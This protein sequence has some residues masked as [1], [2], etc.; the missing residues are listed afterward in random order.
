MLKYVQVSHNDL[1]NR[2]TSKLAT[3]IYDNFIHL[4]FLPEL[5]HTL[6]DINKLLDSPTSF[7][8]LC[9]KNEQIVG[10]LLGEETTLPD[11]RQVAYI[12]YVY[13]VKQF[14]KHGIASKLVNIIETKVLNESKDGVLLTC[15]TEDNS[16]YDFYLK[17]GY[18]P[19][20]QYRKYDKYDLMFKG[21]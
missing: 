6:N 4:S 3:V 13:T 11:G 5:K 17:R 19:D 21:M 2:K 1:M 12:T 16:I 9:L 15:D 14:R 10:Y 7:L 8:Y 18:M 20:M